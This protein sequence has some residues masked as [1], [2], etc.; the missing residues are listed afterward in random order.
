[1]QRYRKQP[2]VTTKP[3]KLTKGVTMLTEGSIDYHLAS[4]AALGHSANSLR[5]YRT[6]LEGFRSWLIANN[7]DAD[8]TGWYELENAAAKYLTA[9]RNEWA[10]KTLQ[11]RLGTIRQWARRVGCRPEFLMDY[12]APTPAP[13]EA[14]PI[15]EG[16]DGVKAMIAGTKNPRHRA[17]VAFCGLLGMRVS[18]AVAV[19]PSDIDLISMAV[20]VRGKGDRTRVIPITWL[21]WTHIEKAHR[22]AVQNGTPTIVRLTVDGARQT[23]RRKAVVAG[24]GH[25]ASHDL[26]ATAATAAYEHTKDIRAVQEILGHA[27][28]QTTVIYTRVTQAAKRAALEFT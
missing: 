26:R 18:E 19:R 25:V 21:A 6:D 7:Y 24:L 14:H 9:H 5:A 28:P 8:D 13:P 15:P 11:R 17:L 4:L 2:V 22:L 1:M 23:I 3:E 20:T 16:I 12:R 27:S 10:P